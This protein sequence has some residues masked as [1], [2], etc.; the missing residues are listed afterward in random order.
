MIARADMNLAQTLDFNSFTRLDLWNQY[1]AQPAVDGLLYFEYAPYSGAHG[2]IEFSTNGKP[3]IAARE[4]L[5][6]GLEEETNVI[7]NV[8][9]AARDPSSPLGYSL[10]AVH[11]WT[12]NLGNVQM[13]VTN[14][15]ADVRVVT[16]DAFSRLVQ[17]NVGRRL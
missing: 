17:A 5:W 11:V 13:V 6:G 15:A 4:M 7:A 10:V 16:P 14:L 9:A 1:L 3:V 2:A 8:N 12:K